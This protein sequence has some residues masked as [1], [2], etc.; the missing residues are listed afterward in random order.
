MTHNNVLSN[1]IGYEGAIETIPETPKDKDIN[2]FLNDDCV[3]ICSDTAYYDDKILTM[4]N[5][6]P[7][8]H[9]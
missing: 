6:T 2:R 4:E 9:K 8:E 3:L 1:G 7:N 5:F